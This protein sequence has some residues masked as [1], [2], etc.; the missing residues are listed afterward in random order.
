MESKTAMIS[1]LNSDN[2]NLIGKVDMKNIQ[3]SKCLEM[4]AEIK[5][6]HKALTSQANQFNVEF[7]KYSEIEYKIKE[8]ILFHFTDTLR[9]ISMI[10]NKY[11]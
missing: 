8:G 4:F 10:M 3:L 2:K 9:S 11:F 1:N 6:A 7:T 5:E